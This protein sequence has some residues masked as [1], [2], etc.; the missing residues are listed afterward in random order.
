MTAYSEHRGN[1]IWSYQLSHHLVFILRQRGWKGQGCPGGAI[2]MHDDTKSSQIVR[3]F[4]NSNFFLH[5]GAAALL[6][7]R[8]TSP[9]H[10]GNDHKTGCVRHDFFL[11]LLENFI[12]QRFHVSEFSS[13]LNCVKVTPRCHRFM[14]RGQIK[15]LS[16][17]FL[18]TVY[19]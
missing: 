4:M 16:L 8:V 15:Q 12:V 9:R 7:F 19:L 18:Q 2:A 5:L 11:H 17:L 10:R 13:R 6:R 3:N 14:Y 1:H